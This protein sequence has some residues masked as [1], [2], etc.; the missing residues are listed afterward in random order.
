[1]RNRLLA[2]LIMALA[3][4]CGVGSLALFVGFPV[5]AQGAA[6]LR[7]SESG[8]LFWDA[9]LSLAFFLQHSGMVRRKFRTRIAGFIPPRYHRALYSI[10]S[11]VVLS[12]VVL[13]W[14]RS[15]H[16]L[17]VLDGPFRWAAGAVA[18]LAFSLFI[19]GALTLRGMDMFGLAPIRAYLSGCPEPA[20][21]FTVQGPYRWVR[22][23]WY[24]CAIML[25]WSSTDL[26]A[27]RLLFN[28][29]WTAWIC[30]GAKLE[31]ADLLNEFGDSY[32][33]YR[34]AVPMLVP[35]RRPALMRP[36]QQARP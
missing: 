22:H 12:S 6:R 21:A 25:F 15:E 4:V 7:W 11:G 17:L 33:K 13:L 14:Q 27:D 36:L 3:V 2:N 18:F 32:D 30:V 5:A 34:Q 8:V 24:L 31:E 10:A 9:L 20:P 23:P 19:W 1:M 28:V 29:L 35:W 16:P 26:T